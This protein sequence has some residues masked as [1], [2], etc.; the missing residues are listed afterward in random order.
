MYQDFLRSSGLS[1]T[2]SPGPRREFRNIGIISDYVRIPYAAG[3]TFAA[4]LLHKE[5]TRRGHQVTIIGP[6]DP[7]ARPEDLPG[8]SVQFPG[9]PIRSQ[10]GF[11]IPMPSR[12]GLR[13]MAGQQL[14]VMIGQTGSS[15]MDA[16]VWLRATRGIPLVTVNT[17]M[18]HS[19][20]DAVLPESLSKR[21]SVQA[22]CKKTIVPFVEQASA[23]VYNQSD[24]LVVLSEG[25]RD[26]WRDLGVTVP[27]HVIPRTIDPH[28]S[29][30]VVGA[31]PF[32]PRAKRGHRILVLCRHVREKGLSR[33]IEIFAQHIAKQRPEASLTMVGD[34]ADHDSFKA[35]VEAL[36]L[37][38]RV[39]F[40]GEV[41]VTQTRNWYAHADMFVYA[42]LSE[43]YGQVVSEAMWA[44][45]PVVAFDDKAGVAQQLQHERTGL[46]LPPGPDRAA[47]DAH[48]GAE[49]CRLLSDA[50][51]RHALAA[52]GRRAA[53]ERVDPDR[54]IRAYYRV[55]AEAKRHRALSKPEGGPIS[56]LKPI[57]HWAAMHSLASV[58]GSIRPA[59]ELNRSGAKQPSWVDSPTA[60]AEDA[61][62]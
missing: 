53:T 42:S 41:E 24:S 23:K 29:S 33:L 34:G 49:V 1:R 26:Y 2:L 62:A 14:D 45:L 9:V 22:V 19:I 8:S 12:D 15:L 38:D 27:I 6:R 56:Q 31:D 25:L 20:Y 17:A 5:F 54:V 50:P 11:F 4:R 40:P 10:P 32:D 61:A 57:L 58:A 39:F 46:L 30:G 7:S 13:E 37:S 51:R 44:G 52:A 59:G 48:F 21:A 3:S 55:F 60:T 36:G 16:G 18:L 35:K 47:A 43:S 28:V